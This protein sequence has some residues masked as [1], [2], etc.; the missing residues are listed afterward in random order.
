MYSIKNILVFIKVLYIQIGWPPSGVS[1]SETGWDLNSCPCPS[2]YGLTHP[3]IGPVPPSLITLSRFYSNFKYS[4][5]IT[6]GSTGTAS[7]PIHAH[8]YS[9]LVY[10]YCILYLCIIYCTAALMSF[11]EFPGINKWRFSKYKGFFQR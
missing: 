8:M 3:Y 7:V 4:I 5:H 10:T 11:M 1:E 9:T 2:L 6:S